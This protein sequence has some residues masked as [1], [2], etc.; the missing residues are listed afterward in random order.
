MFFSNF[1]FKH[2]AGHSAMTLHHDEEVILG[3]SLGYF[4][5]LSILRTLLFCFLVYHFFLFLPLSFLTLPSLIVSQFYVF[6]RPLKVL[7]VKLYIAD[8][9][10][11][12]QYLIDSIYS[13]GFNNYIPSDSDLPLGQPGSGISR[14]CCTGNIALG[15]YHVPN[16]TEDG[17]CKVFPSVSMSSLCSD[18]QKLCIC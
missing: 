5:L 4:C 15:K 3:T 18:D 10:F 9:R 14:Y 8:T 16:W 7:K 2:P 17:V 13:K 12:D 1:L 11:I 6:L